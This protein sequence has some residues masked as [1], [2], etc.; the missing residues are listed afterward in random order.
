ME[1]QEPSSKANTSL[2]E[3]SSQ[4]QIPLVSLL[5]SSSLG[6]QT[7]RDFLLHKVFQQ[8]PLSFQF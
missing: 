1:Y 7:K 4:N 8:A 2:L 3:A 5:V 6:L